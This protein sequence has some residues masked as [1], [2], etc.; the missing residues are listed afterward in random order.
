M[1]TKFPLPRTNPLYKFRSRLNTLHSA[2]GLMTKP[3]QKAA[4]GNATNKYKKAT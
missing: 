2:G 4:G 3:G 1:L